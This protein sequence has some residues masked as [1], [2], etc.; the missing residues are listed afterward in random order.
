MAS[1]D[2]G[3]W[4]MRALRLPGDRSLSDK[5]PKQKWLS[6]RALERLVCVRKECSGASPWLS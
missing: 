6:L 5:C 3:L 1:E 4:L 2:T